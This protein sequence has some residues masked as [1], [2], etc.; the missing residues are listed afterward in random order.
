[1]Y[2]QNLDTIE[3]NVQ[4]ADQQVTFRRIFGEISTYVWQVATGVVE[5]RKAQKIQRST[6]TKMCILLVILVVIAAILGIAIFFVVK[7]RE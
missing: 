7:G 4:Q 2:W 1:M 3:D 6:R 5:L